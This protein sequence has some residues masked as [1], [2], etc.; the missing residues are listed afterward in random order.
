MWWAE[1]LLREFRGDGHLAALVVEGVSAPEALVLHAA[2]GEVPAAALQLTRA[3]P[4]A[5]WAAAEAALVARGWLEVSGDEPAL[6]D[7][8]RAHRQWVEDQTDARALPA[9]EA[10]GEEGCERVRALARPFARAVIDAGLL[11]PDL[12]RLRGEG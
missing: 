2:S 1:T 4:T 3:W 6:T 10:L 11:T 7:T 12:S 5:D 8:G 9:Y